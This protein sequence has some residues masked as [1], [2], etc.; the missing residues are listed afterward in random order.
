MTVFRRETT[1]PWVKLFKTFCLTLS[2]FHKQTRKLQQERER[3]Y[4]KGEREK[5]LCPVICR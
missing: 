1:N 2:Q 3:N 4:M 5:Q